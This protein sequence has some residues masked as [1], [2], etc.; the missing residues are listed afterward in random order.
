MDRYLR[1]PLSD[2]VAIGPMAQAATG[3]SYE[4]QPREQVYG[5][6]GLE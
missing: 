5:P 6:L 1:V 3:E 2:N 4:R